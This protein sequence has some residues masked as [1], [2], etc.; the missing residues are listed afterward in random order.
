MF[1]C[2]HVCTWSASMCRFQSF[3]QYLLSEFYA[4]S[5][6]WICHFGSSEVNSRYEI[7]P[8]G[9]PVSLDTLQITTLRYDTMLKSEKKMYSG[10]YDCFFVFFFVSIVFLSFLF[11]YLFPHHLLSAFPQIPLLSALVTFPNLLAFW[12]RGQTWKEVLGTRAYTLCQILL[13]N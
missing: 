5:H 12:Y 3:D 9:I 1:I 4:A 2:Q 6:S 13:N 8:T 10:W 7:C 11:T